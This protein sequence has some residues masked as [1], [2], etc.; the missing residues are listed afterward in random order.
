MTSSSAEMPSSQNPLD[1]QAI[2]NSDYAISI[3]KDALTHFWPEHKPQNSPDRHKTIYKHVLEGM[4]EKGHSAYLSQFAMKKLAEFAETTPQKITAWFVHRRNELKNQKKL[5]LR[6]LGIRAK[7]S[8]A[9]SLVIELLNEAVHMHGSEVEKLWRFGIPEGEK[10]TVDGKKIKP[11]MKV[12]I[13]VFHRFTSIDKNFM[14]GHTEAALLAE[15]LKLNSPEKVIEWF[16]KRQNAAKRRAMSL[17]ATNVG[18]PSKKSKDEEQNDGD[19]VEYLAPGSPLPQLSVCS[20]TNQEIILDHIAPCFQDDAIQE[21]CGECFAHFMKNEES[22][23]LLEDN[24]IFVCKEKNHAKIFS[25]RTAPCFEIDSSTVLTCS[26]CYL[27][28]MKYMDS[29]YPPVMDLELSEG[30]EDSA[31]TAPIPP[32]TVC[33]TTNKAINIEQMAPC[34]TEGSSMEACGQC[35]DHCRTYFETIYKPHVVYPEMIGEDSM[36]QET[37]EEWNEEIT[38]VVELSGNQAGPV[39][40]VEYDESLGALPDWEYLA[41]H[42]AMRQ[43]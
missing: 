5:E 19:D 29:L 9:D 37:E 38:E 8:E 33:S 42:W 30:D 2:G 3:I 24:N 28:Y 36:P 39:D 22:Y 32:L 43:N 16:T 21:S 4:I 10:I 11:H 41:K 23:N 40:D 1:V 18:P 15:T 26:Q 31:S 20:T 25:D 13:Y 6:P 7:R 35:E 27:H 12:L 14:I 34:Y 17:D